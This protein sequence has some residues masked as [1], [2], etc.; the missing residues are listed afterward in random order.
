MNFI[1]EAVVWCRGGKGGDGCVHFHRE[2]YRP[3]GPP[4]G[5]D[6]GDGG[7]VIFRVSN[8]L[9][10]LIH[11]KYKRHFIAGDGGRGEP[12]NC[13]GKRGE[14]VIVEVPPGTVIKEKNTGRIIAELLKETDSVVVARGGRGGR[15]NAHFK[16]PVNRSPTYAKKGEEG[17]AKWVIVELKLLADVGIVGKPNAGKST[18]LSVVSNARP[19]IAPYPFTT[20]TPQIGTVMI[21]ERESYVIVEVPGL[22]EGASQGRGLGLRFLK[23][24]ERVKVL[25]FLIPADSPDIENEIQC[26]LTEMKNFNEKLLE[27]ERIIAISKAD[28]L[29]PQ[30][31][32]AMKKYCDEHGYI[33]FSS[34]TGYNVDK[35]KFLLWE[36]VGL[37]PPRPP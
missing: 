25:L 27:K 5:G 34:A 8:S 35:L 7:N 24:V 32:E 29:T 36:R 3:K 23:H 10:T 21:S 28:I 26:L 37:F 15:G 16:S 14:D 17:E 11:L 13:T 12:S 1:D 9:R 30:E 20:L 18:L 19:R 4:D 31:M 33:L 22:I 6:G 2:K